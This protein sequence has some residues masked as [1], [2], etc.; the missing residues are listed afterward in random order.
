VIGNK[1]A[2]PDPSER[3]GVPMHTREDMV[4]FSDNFCKILANFSPPPSGRLG[5]AF[6]F[7]YLS[8]KQIDT[9]VFA[10]LV[11]LAY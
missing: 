10:E 7:T 2:S 5:G 1:K 9:M 4:S 6:L 3:R 8:V 11:T